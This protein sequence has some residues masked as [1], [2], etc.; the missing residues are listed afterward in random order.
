MPYSAEISRRNPTC[1][2]FLIDQSGSMDDPFGAESGK[3]KCDGVADAI[4]RLIQTLILRCAKGEGIRDYF[5]IGVIGYGDQVGPAFGG[6]LAG[7]TLVPIGEVANNP[8][9]VEDRTRTVE[10]GAGG[11]VEETIKFPVWF[12]P[13]ADGH[14]PM[15]AALTLAERILADFISQFR[16][17]FPPIV[18]N[19]T[20][21][22]PTDGDPEPAAVAIR[23]L[24][25]NDGN[26]LLFNLHISSQRAALIQFPD[27][28][29]G[30][31]DESARRLFRM[32][33]IL[34][35]SFLAVARE[36]KFNVT[37]AS[38][39]FVFN[40]DLISVIQFLDVGTRVDRN[41]R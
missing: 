36:K 27:S 39:G 15:V 30:L 20:D 3:K 23:D 22:E 2:L 41:L 18:L 9:R 25:T 37:E 17:S 1:F 31:P 32:S 6:P 11:L 5:H 14:T 12:E 40:A 38:R 33:S 4:N 26:V 19:L 16:A 34:P 28:D 24:A 29:A 35:A 13:R 7:R 21:G 10:D 8:L